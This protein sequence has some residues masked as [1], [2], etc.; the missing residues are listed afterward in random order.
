LRSRNIYGPYEERIVLAQGKPPVNGP[1]QGGWVETPNG[2]SWFMH[3]QDKGPFGRVVHLQPM[4]WEDGWPV[5]GNNGEPVLRHAKPWT[6]AP[7]PRQTPPDSDEFNQPRIGPQWQWEANPQPGWA[8]PSQA[9]GALRL[10]CVR[11]P[12]VSHGLYD[13]PNL[14]LQKFPAPEFTATAKLKFAP[15]ADGD[16]TGLLIFAPA[17]AVLAIQKRG[18]KLELSLA[19]CDGADRGAAEVDGQ[20]VPLP[21]ADGKCRFSYSIDGTTY[22]T[23]GELFQARKGAWIGAKVGLFAT[24]SAPAA[25]YG[26]ADFDWFRVE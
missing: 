5:I 2:E 16:K 25:E 4:R 24:S 3:F 9:L 14:L 23:V 11:P 17:Y 21:S 6:A 7:V 19:T 18:E 22:T 10:F 26:Y 1:H 8:L 13:L 20:A 15:K 12:P